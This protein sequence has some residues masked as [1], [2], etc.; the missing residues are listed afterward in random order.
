MVVDALSYS[1]NSRA[2]SQE[3]VIGISGYRADIISDM[4]RSCMG[5]RYECRKQ[6]ATE[7]NF[8]CSRISLTKF[9][10]TSLSKSVTIFPSAAIRSFIS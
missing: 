3:Q 10:V 8:S 2:T 6:I 9:E 5:L 4:A 1:L 7:S